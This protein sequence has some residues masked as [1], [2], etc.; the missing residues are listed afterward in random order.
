MP[1][2]IDGIEQ[3]LC[4]KSLNEQLVPLSDKHITTNYFQYNKCYLPLGHEGRCLNYYDARECKDLKQL[5][6]VP[7][8]ERIATGAGSKDDFRRGR[9]WLDQQLR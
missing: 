6:L 9:N 4:R 7:V 8:F 2:V 3:Q 5:G 1:L